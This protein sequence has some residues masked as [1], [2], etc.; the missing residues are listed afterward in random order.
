MWL[1]AVVAVAFTWWARFQTEIAGVSGLAAYATYQMVV[2]CALLNRH[3]C[4]EPIGQGREAIVPRALGISAL[5]W[6]LICMGALALPRSAWSND[7]A[8]L[9]GLLFG[10]CVR[11]IVRGKR[12]GLEKRPSISE[13]T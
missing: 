6:L 9:V 3:P 1:S 2:G 8:I 10:L 11:I 5:A 7:K 13:V 12:G 4:G